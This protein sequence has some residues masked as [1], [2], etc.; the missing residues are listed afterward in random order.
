[1]VCKLMSSIVQEKAAGS[2]EVARDDATPEAAGVLQLVPE[3]AAYAG[4]DNFRAGL[5][6]VDWAAKGKGLEHAG[7]STMVEPGSSSESEVSRRPAAPAQK[8]D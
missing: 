4:Q 7:P 5:P 1:M 6:T 8:Q 2:A 3:N